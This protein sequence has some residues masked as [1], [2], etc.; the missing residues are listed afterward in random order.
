MPPQVAPEVLSGVGYDGFAAD[1]WSL[2]VCLFAMLAGFFP[3]SEAHSRGARPHLGPYKI[4][5]Y[6]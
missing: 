2:G 3:L 1:V 5:F 4:L 6:F